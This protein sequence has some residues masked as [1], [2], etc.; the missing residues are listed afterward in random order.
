M[1]I[2]IFIFGLIIGSFL[3]VI[4]YR[5]KNGGRIVWDRSKCPNCKKELTFLD[6]IPVLSF[7][8]FK[9]RCRYCK[10]KI[11]WQYPL[12][13]LATTAVFV[14]TFFNP[15][16]LKI[17]FPLFAILGNYAFLFLLFLLSSLLV[18]FV[19][20]LKYYLIPDV[21]LLPA[22]LVSFVFGLLSIFLTS[23]L[24]IFM[25]GIIGALVF[26][27]FFGVQYFLSRGKWVG[28]GDIKLGFLLGFILGW[29]LA[30]VSLVLAYI[31]GSLVALTLM[32]LGRKTRKDI[33]PF[34]PFLIFSF[35]LCLFYGQA[36]LDWY[37][38]F[39]F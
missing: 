33:L 18:V 28:G 5:L 19:Y 37:L 35:F 11:S 17:N 3:N 24:N 14:F 2:L 23:S 13:E 30:L 6:L 4:I 16:L 22:I 1:F 12:V 34:G 26:S 20:D 32:A 29:K 31:F 7:I 36:I 27:G 21:V 9:G 8:F 15:N 10:E 38:N 25:E 39:L